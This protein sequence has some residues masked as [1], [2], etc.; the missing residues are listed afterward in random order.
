MTVWR[1]TGN[2]IRTAITIRPYICTFIKSSY[3]FRL[4][5]F[6]SVLR[7]ISGFSV[8]VNFSVPL[9]CVCALP[10][11][12]VLKITYKTY[13]VEQD[14]KTYSLTHR[15]SL[16]NVCTLQMYFFHFLANFAISR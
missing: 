9:L 4:K 11:K 7:S 16:I 3:N 2:I 6:F 10:G 1:I 8:K 13:C 5:Q 15:G 14:V 12:A